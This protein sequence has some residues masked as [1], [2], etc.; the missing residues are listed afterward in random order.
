VVLLF[1]SGW[2]DHLIQQKVAFP[3]LEND[4]FDDRDQWASTV[5]R[6][7][8]RGTYVAPHDVKVAYWLSVAFPQI[9]STPSRLNRARLICGDSESDTE[10]VHDISAIFRLTFE[11]GQG[12]RLVRTIARGLAKYAAVEALDDDEDSGRQLLSFL[13]NV[14]AVGTEIADTRSWT[15]LPDRIHVA[16]LRLPAG[17]Q[18]VVVEI[19]D[20]RGRVAQ[21]LDFGEVEVVAGSRTLIHHRSF[22]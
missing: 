11:E 10:P 15:M 14:V 13:A 4:D 7:G 2:V 5:R 18:P 19:L 22:E 12:S 20:D 21:R 9:A 3:I 8:P 6:R 1:E 17:L 16:R